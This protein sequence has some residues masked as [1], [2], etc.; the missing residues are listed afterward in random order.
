MTSVQELFWKFMPHIDMYKTLK[1]E[2]MN[3]QSKIIEKFSYCTSTK[4]FLFFDG[5]NLENFLY[6]M[7]IFHYLSLSFYMVIHVFTYYGFIKRKCIF[8]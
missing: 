7:N 1:Y 6:E 5:A 3:N 8:Q 4:H 2:N